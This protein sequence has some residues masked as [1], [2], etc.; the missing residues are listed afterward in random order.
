MG[1]KIILKCG[2]DSSGD[3]SSDY[4]KF[5]T[6]TSSGV[7]VQTSAGG[8]CIGVLANKPDSTN[9]SASVQHLGVA[10]V[11]AGAAAIDVSGGP[12]KV[13]NTNAGKAVTAATGNHVHGVAL[14]STTGDGQFLDV[15]L[16]IG[17]APL[18]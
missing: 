13:S 4:G 15:L 7:A 18:P 6:K 11:M 14:T 9:K 1:A 12:V 5:V 8:I 17:G 3:L 10:R 16:G 2:Y